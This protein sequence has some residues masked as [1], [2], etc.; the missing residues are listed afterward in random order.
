MF[1][2]L[3]VPQSGTTCTTLWYNLDSGGTIFY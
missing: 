3:L 1:F 2:F